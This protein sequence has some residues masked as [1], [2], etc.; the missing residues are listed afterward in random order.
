MKGDCEDN[1]F[2]WTLG[3]KYGYVTFSQRKFI[4]KLKKY[5]K[6]YSEVTILAENDDGSIYA[7]VPVTWFKFSPPKKGREFTEEEK[8]AVAERM[9]NAREKRKNI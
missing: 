9:R 3:D 4:S 5:A 1:C 2:E 7:K 6:E 8:A